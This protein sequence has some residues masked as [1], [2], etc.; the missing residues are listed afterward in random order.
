MITIKV[1]NSL[2]LAKGLNRTQLDMLRKALRYEERTGRWVMQPLRD[3]KGGFIL[4]PRTRKPVMRRTPEIKK[5]NLMTKAG[6]FPTGLLYIVEERL[7]KLA[8]PYVVE[9][10]RVAPKTR[11]AGSGSMFIPGSCPTPYPEQIDAARA[12]LEHGRGIIAAPTGS[13]KSLIAALICDAFQVRTLIVV[14]KVELKSQLTQSLREYFRHDA[15]GPAVDGRCKHWITVENVDALR[16]KGVPPGAD[17]LLIDEFHHAGAATYRNLNQKYWND[18][19]FKIGLTATPFRSRS[20]ERLLLES[21]LSKVI[22]RIEYQQA[23]DAGYIVPVEAFF[24]R[25]PTTVTKAH[26]FAAV[27]RDLVTENEYRNRLITYLAANLIKNDKSTLILTK[28]VQHGQT[29]ES[30][31]AD[32]GIIAP[33]AEGA[34]G[35]LN[36]DLISAFNRQETPALIGTNGILGE[37]VDTKP[38]EWMILGGLGKSRVQFMQQCGRTVRKFPGKESGKIVLFLDESHRWTESHF[39]AQCDYLLEEYGIT[40]TELELPF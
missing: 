3:T 19:Y 37:G 14:P 15:V 8:L 33:F 26:S 13:G 10:T 34:K 39:E 28:I 35:K 16:T 22:Y 1:G 20:E 2:C 36:G 7:T 32:Q 24:Y 6:E 27:Y 30:M 17:M 31:L 11:L 40:P 25:L 38:C 18:V 4:D 5:L 29:I 12:A 23:V 21:V 9:D